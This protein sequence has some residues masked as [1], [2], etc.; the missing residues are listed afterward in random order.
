MNENN[1]IEYLF[2]EPFALTIVS[3]LMLMSVLSWYVIIKKYLVLLAMRWRQQRLEKFFQQ[4]KDLKALMDYAQAKK[5]SSAHLVSAM[6][7]AS[8]HYR[9]YQKKL[10]ASV[11]SNSQLYQFIEKNAEETLAKEKILLQKGLTLLASIGALAPFVGLLGTVMSI[12]FALMKIATAGNATL[13]VV[14]APIG[15]ALILTALGL[16]VALPAVLFYN[17]ILRNQKEFFAQL[18]H[19]SYQLAVYLSTGQ[20]LPFNHQ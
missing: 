6:I 13:A 8:L 5:H 9:A 16:A 19:F 12:Y 15:E 17:L 11:E 1:I 2:S 3:I 20:K 7:Y 18:Q 14:A 10:A 4:N